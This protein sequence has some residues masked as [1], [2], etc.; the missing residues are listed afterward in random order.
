MFIIIFWQTNLHEKHRVIISKLTTTSS[1]QSMG[2]FTI[3]ASNSSN[4]ITLYLF[5]TIHWMPICHKTIV[6][7]WRPTG[8]PHQAPLK[9]LNLLTYCSNL[10]LC[11][12][13]SIASHWVPPLV[14]LERAQ[15]IDVQYP[16]ELP[17]ILQNKE[18]YQIHSVCIWN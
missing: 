5:F 1:G 16:T 9:W 4:F 17:F 2:K 8:F 14:S 3:L 6:Q 12:E 18:M 10:S 11:R 7:V 13:T 15:S